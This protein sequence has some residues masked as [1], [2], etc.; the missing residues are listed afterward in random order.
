[1]AT[2]GLPPDVLLWLDHPITKRA[3]PIPQDPV[4]AL[5]TY[6]EVVTPA[7]YLMV[8]TFTLF[9]YDMILTFR[10]ESTYIRG[11][12]L[13]CE[14]E[15]K[16]LAAVAMFCNSVALCILGLRVWAIW[17]QKL[18]MLALLSVI[19]LG[20]VLSPSTL[21]G[22]EV[23]K[24]VVIDNPL[25][26]ILTGCTI[27]YQFGLSTKWARFYVCSLIYDSSLLM[28]TLLK[29]WIL[30]K[31][32]VRIPI[33]T[34]L[35]RDG[36]WYFLVSMVSVG[37]TTVGSS[38]PETEAAALLSIFSIATV[39]GASSRLLLRLREFYTPKN[40]T[41]RRDASR[42]IGDIAMRD[43]NSRSDRWTAP[44]DEPEVATRATADET[45]RIDV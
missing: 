36:A 6:L 11:L 31:G 23:Q 12:Q 18:W 21:V 7:K 13:R 43:Y 28:L 10:S 24:L 30:R 42:W 20:S 41:S 37:L 1:M 16:L 15:I 40:Y 38:F 2:T 27:E 39:A 4:A 17:D 3:P 8:A 14:V 9:I 5:K 22:R 29:A 44:E 35:T 33:M 19:F 45:S 34:Q 25:P 32:G 26:G